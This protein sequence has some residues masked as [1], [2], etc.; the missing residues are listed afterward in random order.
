MSD[1][2]V[3][4]PDNTI[5]PAPSH[6]KYRTWVVGG[7]EYKVPVGGKYVEIVDY[8]DILSVDIEEGKNHD[9]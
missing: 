7:V 1:V 3:N 8:S 4:T 2:I 6:T 5:A 9:N